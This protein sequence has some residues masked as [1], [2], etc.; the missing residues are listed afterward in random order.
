MFDRNLSDL[1]NNFRT[2][3]I[4]KKINQLNPD[5]IA[6]QE[7]FDKDSYKL[8]K[9]LLPQY[10]FTNIVGSNTSIF[11]GKI[12]NGGVVLASKYP[13]TDIKEIVFSRGTKE[14][15]MSSKGAISG[16]IIKDNIPINI[17]SLHLQSGRKEKAFNIKDT[18]FNDLQKIINYKEPTIIVG[19]FNINTN[20][21]S[22]FFDK[23]TD[24]LDLVRVSP[25]VSTSNT[26]FKDDSNN[27]LD[28]LLHNKTNYEIN[29][30]PNVLKGQFR[31]NEGYKVEEKGLFK[32]RKG[33]EN[34]FKH[35]KEKY[36]ELSD[37]YPVLFNVNIN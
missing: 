2:K 3:E 30:I 15:K 27:I 20:K 6:F 12:I 4:S 13:L 37:H 35:Q 36:Y 5:V 1:R 9:K 18:Q 11:Q 25:V 33:I 8:F 17:I 31:I 26:N 32:I 23:E 7:L 14:D 29:A 10:H 22:N 16:R 28:H 24:K 34:V 21:F 19:D